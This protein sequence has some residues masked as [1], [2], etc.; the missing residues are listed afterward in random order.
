MLLPMNGY[1]LLVP[2]VVVA[3]IVT[4]VTPEE[5][6]DEDA[7]PWFLGTIYWRN[8]RVPLVSYEALTGGPRPLMSPYCRIAVVN[9]TGLSQ[10]LDFFALLLQSTPR[11]LRLTAEDITPDDEKPVDTGQKLHVKVSGEEAI[12]PDVQYVEQAVINYLE[13]A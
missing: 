4:F 7:P 3:E 9:K 6:H 12:V 2:G 13:M 1:N 10:Q 11:L 5:E 8:Q